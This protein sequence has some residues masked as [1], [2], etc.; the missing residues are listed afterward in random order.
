LFIV[1]IALVLH[2][3]KLGYKI[4]DNVVDPTYFSISL[5]PW[6]AIVLSPE[7]AKE[8]KHQ[9][10]E[11]DEGFVGAKE[12]TCSWDFFQGWGR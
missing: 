12:W 5:F 3:H 6:K 2:T 4:E 7:V 1:S 11:T 10:V 9:I 8:N